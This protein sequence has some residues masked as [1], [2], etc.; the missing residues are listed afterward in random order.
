[1]DR[2]EM[3][4]V[5]V[6]WKDWSW[7]LVNDRNRNVFQKNDIFFQSFHAGT[8]VANKI[9]ELLLHY[10]NEEQ[11]GNVD[12]LSEIFFVLDKIRSRAEA[13]FEIIA[14][15]EEIR[16]YKEEEEPV[17]FEVWDL[18]DLHSQKVHDAI[19]KAV[20]RVFKQASLSTADVKMF[21]GARNL[22]SKFVM[23]WMFMTDFTAPGSDAV[24]PFLSYPIVFGY[25]FE[26]DAFVSNLPDDAAQCTVLLFVEAFLFCIEQDVISEYHEHV[27]LDELEVISEL[28]RKEFKRLAQEPQRNE[29]RLI[30]M[31][32]ALD[33][34]TFVLLQKESFNTRFFSN[35]LKNADSSLSIYQ[36]SAVIS[37]L[38]FC[39]DEEDECRLTN[40]AELCLE[41]GECIPRLLA[42]KSS[43]HPYDI[44][45]ALTCVCATLDALF[46]HLGD[47]DREKFQTFLLE[48]LPS[49]DFDLA[50]N[51][52]PR[53]DPS[54]G[55]LCAFSFSFEQLFAGDAPM[56]DYYVKGSVKAAD[57]AIYLRMMAVV[58]LTHYCVT[59]NYF[60]SAVNDVNNGQ[61]M[62]LDF[63]EKLVSQRNE[64]MLIEDVLCREDC[65]SFITSEWAVSSMMKNEF[66]FMSSIVNGGHLDMGNTHQSKPAEHFC[67]VHLLRWRLMEE[68]YQ[69][70]DL[71]CLV[72]EGMNLDMGRGVF[73][74]QQ[75]FALTPKQQ[76]HAM[77][78]FQKV[79]CYFLKIQVRFL[80]YF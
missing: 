77:K 65:F 14:K 35:L 61:E 20:Y 21:D 60:L 15:K 42:N 71:F 64:F 57:Y 28:H 33:A 59:L 74:E 49:M 32:R 53:S 30:L 9:L 8:E 17:L 34:C 12:L 6:I 27:Q 68:F 63:R 48:Y 70:V 26:G 25:K 54:L 10:C 18:L 47:M 66:S 2:V 75:Q 67:A 22:L 40:L 38:I 46:G 19:F 36:I 29:V 11:E 69:T 13:K 58:I 43:D 76:D 50:K 79:Y 80:P 55:E 23:N 51:K 56:A 45:H 1:V 3:A 37:S 16:N 78:G 39:K 44:F 72:F 62:V 41:L 24:H 5:L 52:I 73:D 7:R 4:K 31:L